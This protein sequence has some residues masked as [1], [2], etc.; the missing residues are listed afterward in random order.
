MKIRHVKDVAT[1]HLGPG[2]ALELHY[3]EHDEKTGKKVLDRVL[4]AEP[5]ERSLKVDRIAIVD[6]DDGEELKLLGM[7]DAIG[8]VF[9]EGS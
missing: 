7:N 5:L 4:H 9:G 1:I 6:F 2:D 8:G 3:E